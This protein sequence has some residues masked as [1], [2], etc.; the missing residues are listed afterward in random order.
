MK[1]ERGMAAGVVDG[2]VAGVIAG[3]V[4]KVARVMVIGD[5]G[6][7]ILREMVEFEGG[8]WWW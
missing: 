5:F 7:G 6:G 3:V 4:D 2:V 1:V 8:R